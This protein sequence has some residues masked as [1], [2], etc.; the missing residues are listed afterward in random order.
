MPGTGP[1]PSTQAQPRRVVEGK[2]RPRYCGA[3][4]LFVHLKKTPKK[5]CSRCL[6]FFGQANKEKML[7]CCHVSHDE[8][9]LDRCSKLHVFFF[10]GRPLNR[11]DKRFR[12]IISEEFVLNGVWSICDPAGVQPPMTDSALLPPPSTT[13][14]LESTPATWTVTGNSPSSFPLS[15]VNFEGK[16]SPLQPLSPLSCLSPPSLDGNPN[17]LENS[18][19]FLDDFDD[20]FS[21][22]EFLNLPGLPLLQQQSVRD[23]ELEAPPLPDH[24]L[25]QQSDLSPEGTVNRVHG[26]PDPNSGGLY[27]R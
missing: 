1:T 19:H 27:M 4:G 16:N 11:G 12:Q 25:Q 7:E 22:H 10:G 26:P 13:P 2:S 8:S 17:Q 14:R 3:V 20:L 5:F 18:P 23:P 6:D 24:S 9:T 21:C 15:N